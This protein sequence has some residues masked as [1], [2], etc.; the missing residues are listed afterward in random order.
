MLDL[1]VV[2]VLDVHE[3]LELDLVPL[4]LLL[5]ADDARILRQL[6]VLLLR[7]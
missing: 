2:L 6:G 5:E 4:E 3:V 7:L 1:L